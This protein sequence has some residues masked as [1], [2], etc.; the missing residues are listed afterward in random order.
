MPTPTK[1]FYR[2]HLPHLQP[3]PNRRYFLTTRL[4]GSLPATCK[5]ITRLLDHGQAFAHW[6]HTLDRASTGPK[7]LANPQIAQLVADALH[8]AQDKLNLYR[9]H[10]WVIMSN[11]IHLLLTAHSPLPQ[12]TKA[13]KNYT[14]RQA[15]E[16][17][18]RQ[19]HP[20]WRHETYDH[21]IRHDDEFSRIHHYIEQNP[22][23]AGLVSRPEDYP[24]SSA[25]PTAR[26]ASGCCAVRQAS[27][28]SGESQGG[29]PY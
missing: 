14:A 9:L 27:G 20:F 19:G 10:A 22:V 3:E 5:P 16:I 29:S 12:I 24:W 1:P 26:Q 11:H 13:I 15:N 4:A 7:H 6:D 21:L 25:N 28:L 8:F 17:L 2:R 18:H 23:A